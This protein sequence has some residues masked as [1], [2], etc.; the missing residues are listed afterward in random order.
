LSEAVIQENINRLLSDEKEL[1]L[2]ATT[3]QVF[4]IAQT[5]SPEK[6]GEKMSDLYSGVISRW[7]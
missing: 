6:E 2:T 3:K 7:V 4:K 5:F 1:E